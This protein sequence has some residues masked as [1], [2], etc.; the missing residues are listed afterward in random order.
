MKHYRKLLEPLSSKSALTEKFVLWVLLGQL[1]VNLAL[2]IRMPEGRRFEV[3][4][5]TA[6]SGSCIRPM[7]PQAQDTYQSRPRLER[8]L[9]LHTDLEIATAA[10]IAITYSHRFGNR[11]DTGTRGAMR[12]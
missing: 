5:E 9:L 10:A 2:H 3:P 4:E 8:V 1:G 11:H 7:T 6:Q 12:V